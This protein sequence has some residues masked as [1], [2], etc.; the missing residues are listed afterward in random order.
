MEHYMNIVCGIWK[1]GKKM[2][3]TG[4]SAIVWAE[5]IKKEKEEQKRKDEADNTRKD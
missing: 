5:I 1:K 2:S 3:R 4:T